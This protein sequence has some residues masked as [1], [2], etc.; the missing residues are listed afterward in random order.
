M[1][2]LPSENVCSAGPA[3]WPG[4]QRNLREGFG[5][6][7]NFTGKRLEVCSNVEALKPGMTDFFNV[8]ELIPRPHSTENLN[9]S[10]RASA[11]HMMMTNTWMNTNTEL[12]FPTV[13]VFWFCILWSCWF[14]SG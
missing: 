9:D 10:T 2:W 8:E 11:V 4:L 13:L 7:D 3:M 6:G 1:C 14:G 12:E 5:D